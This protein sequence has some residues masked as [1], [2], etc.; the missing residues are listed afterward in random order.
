MT[1]GLVIAAA[2]SGSGKTT[3]TLGL[4]AALHESGLKVQPFKCGPDYIDPAFHTAVVGRRSINLDSWA[5]SAGVIRT[6][7]AKACDGMDIAIAEGAMGLFDGAVSRGACGNGAAADVATVTAWPVI[8]VLDAASQAQSAAAVAHGFATYRNDVS[9]AGVILNKVASSRHETLLRKGFE[10]IDIDVLG[11]LPRNEAATLPGRH[12]GLVQAAEL[13]ALQ[14]QLRD[15]GAMLSEHCDLDAMLDH[16]RRAA[17]EVRTC[18]GEARR[19]DGEAKPAEAAHAQPVLANPPGQHIAIARDEAFSFLYPHQL[20][21]W[22][23]AGATLS[24][25][26]PLAD[27]AP[28]TRAD[29]CWLPGGYPELHA[30][31]LANARAFRSGMQSFARD[32]SVHGECGGYMAMGAGLVDAE[33]QRHEMLGLLGLETSF[34]TPRRHLGYRRARLLHDIPGHHAHSI[35]RGHEFHYSTAL[36]QPDLPLADVT[37][38][39]GDPVAETG[40]WRRGPSGNTLSGSYFHL[41]AADPSSPST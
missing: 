1:P 4:L 11:A 9:V 10:S 7:V 36:V 29:V 22:Q 20:D 41:I 39:A 40:A 25:F 30:A 15:I 23:S 27:E 31:R 6:Q 32:R 17:Q 5:M 2:S 16:A 35:L 12:L 14:T 8:L 37:D 21:A 3:V 33:G 38:A 18:H 19:R 24:F 13:P 28:D 34:A 26:S